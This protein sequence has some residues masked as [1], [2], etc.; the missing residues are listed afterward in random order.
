MIIYPSSAAPAPM[1]LI[2]GTGPGTGKSTIAGAIHTRLER[3]R[4]PV[5]CWYEIEVLQQREF[6]PFFDRFLDGDAAMVDALKA[7]V[8]TYLDKHLD[9]GAFI[10]E[11][12]LPCV[13]WLLLGG[14]SEPDIRAWCS[15]LR[16]RVADRAPMLVMLECP[17]EQGIE[18]ARDSRGDAWFEQWAARER[19]Y[20][21]YRDNPQLD[22]TD[23]TWLFAREKR[24]FDGAFDWPCRE[25]RTDQQTVDEIVTALIG[26]PTQHA[27]PAIDL[28]HGR[29]RAAS[30]PY[31]RDVRIEANRVLLMGTALELIGQNDG[32]AR[33]ATSNSTLTRDGTTIVM[34]SK[35][36]G[37]VP[38]LPV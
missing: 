6:R 21:L 2:V 15:W 34:R 23:R 18:R 8:S 3:S 32:S 22:P 24:C 11:S 4:Q 17:R 35:R 13:R 10:C 37:Q 31:L 5:H 33:I 25:F 20:P 14:V 28:P 9:D 36:F 7:S 30:N 29:W 27:D 12:L 1:L 26:T 19:N 38:L 16:D